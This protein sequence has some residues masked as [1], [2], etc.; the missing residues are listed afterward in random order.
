MENHKMR[1]QSDIIWS[2]VATLFIC[3][4]VTIHPNIP[5]RNEGPILSLLRRIKLIVLTLVVP[6]L[7]LIWAYRQWALATDIG[8]LF[9][10]ENG[11]SLPI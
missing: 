3:T 6:E 9:K 7:M 4:W 11:S 8:E 1:T 10:G 2:C 5:P